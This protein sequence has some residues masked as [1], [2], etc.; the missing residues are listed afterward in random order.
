MYAVSS[1]CWGDY[2]YL[3]LEKP[4]EV[5]FGQFVQIWW[6]SVWQLSTAALVLVPYIIWSVLGNFALFTIFWY[7]VAF[8]S[9]I[10]NRAAAEEEGAPVLP[11]D[12][13]L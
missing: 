9:F 5:N 10:D 7:E 1:I 11:E 13:W 2:R 4:L 3:D 8:L 12:E 6:F